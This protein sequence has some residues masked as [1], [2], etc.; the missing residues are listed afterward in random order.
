MREREKEDVIMDVCPSCRGIWLDA[1]E[2]EKLSAVEDR[3]YRSRG[4]RDDDDDD[5][6]RRRQDDPR[7]QGQPDPRYRGQQPYGQP[8]KKKSGFLGNIFEGFGGGDD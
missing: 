4:W 5:D 3:Y 7:Y 1:G 6:D 2:L 8:Y